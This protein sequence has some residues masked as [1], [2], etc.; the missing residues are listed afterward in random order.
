MGRVNI[1]R[2]RK[3]G[4]KSWHRA[5]VMHDFYV[6]NNPR[7]KSG[8][9]AAWATFAPMRLH[10]QNQCES[11]NTSCIL[12]PSATIGG[13]R[14]TCIFGRS[15]RLRGFVFLLKQAGSVPKEKKIECDGK[16]TNLV[17]AKKKG[18][19]RLTSFFL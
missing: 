16:T 5:S 12:A 1:E 3:K 7:Q 8:D 13:A 11:M 19:T 18:G 14:S 2:R 4:K 6:K 15:A 17:V 9:A 10:R